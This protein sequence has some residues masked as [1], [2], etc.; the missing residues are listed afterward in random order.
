LN[1]TINRETVSSEASTIPKRG[2][3]LKTIPKYFIH[4]F[5]FSIIFIALV[6]IWAFIFAVLIV[7]GSFIGFI[8]GFIVLFFFL[9]G[10]NSF[11]T[12]LIWSIPIKTAWKSLLGHGLL[13]FIV[14]II[15]HIP[16]AV[17]ELSVSGLATTIALFTFNAFIDGFIA[18]N[19]AGWWKEESFE[20]AKDREARH[21]EKG[22]DE[23]EAERI[24]KLEEEGKL[25]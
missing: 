11:L 19:V 12:D 15:V 4:G 23:G 13:L 20:Y 6:F 3:V 1:V 2:S 17:I 5:A 10:L 18:K 16:A 22:I 25:H 7:I 8:L 9:G 24:R 21:G 14:L